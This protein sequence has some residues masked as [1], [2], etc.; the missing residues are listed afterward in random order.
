MFDKINLFLGELVIRNESD[1]FFQTSE[2][3]VLPSKGVLPK[4]QIKPETELLSQPKNHI[5]NKRIY[6]T[7]SI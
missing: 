7:A 6:E 4:I 5:I 2:N 3:S 1:A